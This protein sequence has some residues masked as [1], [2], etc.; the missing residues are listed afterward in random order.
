MTDGCEKARQDLDPR[1]GTWPREYH[2]PDW[3]AFFGGLRPPAREPAAPRAKV[4]GQLTQPQ[5]E[6]RELARLGTGIQPDDEPGKGGG[7]R[8]RGADLRRE[9]MGQRDA[10]R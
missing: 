1:A 3:R 2:D 7:R 4:P 10:P 9:I 8:H 5:G 6:G